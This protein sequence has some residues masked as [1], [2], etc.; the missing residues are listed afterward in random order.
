VPA[1]MRVSEQGRIEVRNY[2]LVLMPLAA[3]LLGVAVWAFRRSNEGKPYRPSTLPPPDV[4]GP[5]S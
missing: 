3:A 5:A 2:V 4:R 1:G